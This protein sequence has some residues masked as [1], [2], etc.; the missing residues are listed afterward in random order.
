MLRCEALLLIEHFGRRRSLSPFEDG[1]LSKEGAEHLRYHWNTLM[2]GVGYYIS[3]CWSEA[4]LARI[5]TDLIR[6]MEV[7]RPLHQ[8]LPHSVARTYGI[9]SSPRIMRESN[10][11]PQHTSPVGTGIFHL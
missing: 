6:H 4:A 10:D 1:L 11:V 5:G 3:I 2:R 7:A 9:V 8:P